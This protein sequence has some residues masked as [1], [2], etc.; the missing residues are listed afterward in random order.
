MLY[1]FAWLLGN[2]HYH[3]GLQFASDMHTLYI[4]PVLLRERWEAF[5]EYSSVIIDIE[6]HVAGRD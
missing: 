4:L 5:C 3:D 2:A 1:G 6:V